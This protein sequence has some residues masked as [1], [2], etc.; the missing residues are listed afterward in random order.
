MTGCQCS[1]GKHSFVAYIALLIM[2]FGFSSAPLAD[3][4]D[5]SGDRSW[6]ASL[7]WARNT[8]DRVVD[9]FFSPPPK[10]RHSDLVGLNLG[11]AFRQGRWFRW[12][13]EGQLVQHYRQQDHLES[14]L[15]LIARKMSTPWDDTLDTRFAIGQG[16][17]WAFE[18]PS[19]EPRPQKGRGETTQLLNY[20]MLEAEV[21]MPGNDRLSLFA[22]LHHRSG[23]FGLFDGVHGGSNFLGVGVRY[24]F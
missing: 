15:T 4:H 1:T 22:R 13:L 5:P 8:P 10:I 9:I 18:E 24:G 7:Y 16:L 3:D 17:S 14:N 12:E 20:I 2:L 23:I 11:Y 19:L 21:V 6:F